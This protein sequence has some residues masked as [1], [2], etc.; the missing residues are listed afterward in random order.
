MAALPMELWVSPSG[1]DAAPGTRDAPLATI[2]AALGAI[3]RRG[4][5]AGSA[6]LLAD[7][8]H[9]LDAPLELGPEDSGNPGAPLTFAA[10]P[11]ARPLLSAGRRLRCDWKPYR[12]GIYRST[13]PEYRDGRAGFAQLFVN[14][15]RQIRARFPNGDSASPDR[16]AYAPVVAADKWPHKEILVDRATFS[17]RTW[18]HPEEAVLHVFP[19][20]HWGNTQYRVRGFDRD[21]GALLLGEGGWQLNDQWSSGVATHLGAG[22]RFFVENVFEELDSPGEWYLDR[23]EGVLSYMPPAGVDLRVA[24]IEVPVHAR[25]V[26]LVGTRERPVHDIV[27]RGICFANT[28]VTYLEPYEAPSLGDWTIRRDGAVYLSGVERCEVQGCRFEPVGGN[29][30]FVDGYARGVRV[31]GCLFAWTGES[32]VCLVGKSHLRSGV[33]SRCRYCGCEH[34][35]SWG[36]PSPDIPSECVVHDNLIRDIGVFGKQTAGVFVSLASGV[37]VSHNHICRTPRAAICLND[38]LHGGHTIEHNDIHDTV[39]E[40]GDHGPF[41]S[42]GREAYWCHDQSHGPR[43]HPAGDVLAY[44]ARTTVIRH[45]RFR[46]YSGWGIDLDDGTSNFHVYRNLCFGISIKLREGDH[47]LVENNIFVNG[48]N[49]PGFHIGYEGNDD[50]FVRNIVVMSSAHDNPEIDINYEKGKSEGNVYD[51]IG[52]PEKGPWF[53]EWDRNLLWSDVGLF[54]MAVHWIRTR[55][56]R[57]EVL[58]LADW[59]ALGFDRH[60]VFADPLFQDAARGD[61]RLRPDS[62]A[63][64]LGIQQVEM[65][66][67]GL[68]AAFP[69]PEE[70]AAER[71]S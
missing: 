32:A 41:N 39:R 12:D 1:S 27:F 56:S 58:T 4:A 38:G 30:V 40:T 50:R 2:G 6:I 36:E 67:F 29:G 24:R 20:N 69:F 14:G 61:Y 21:R 65:D 22:S 70:E 28:E 25:A 7:G 33:R 16:S 49:P 5:P 64:A 31:E 63:F 26:G 34:P 45:N 59:R 8:T 57:T 52:P 68:T 37:T 18:S 46:D 62:P 11:G 53:G 44:A 48:A 43:S 10:A 35:W 17:A 19:V 3:R 23:R 13:L 42:W 55:P 66:G 51:I 54:R 15:R 60:S 71:R 47:R 9:E